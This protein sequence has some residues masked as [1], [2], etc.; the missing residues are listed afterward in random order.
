MQANGCAGC[1]GANLTGGS[2]GPKLYGIEHQLSDAQ[3][4]DFIIHPRPPMPNFGFSP[5]QVK[6]VV[7]YLS[8]LDGGTNASAPVVT[9]S[10]TARRHR[11]D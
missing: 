9:L 1:H 10:P 7:A 2:V 8:S 3:I 11:D 4:S 6:D 5:Q